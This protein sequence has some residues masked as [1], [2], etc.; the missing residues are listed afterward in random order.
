MGLPCHAG[1]PAS[2]G[3][4]EPCG[5][6]HQDPS[7]NFEPRLQV[8]KVLMLEA[9]VWTL[10]N[11]GNA[12]GIQSGYWPPGQKHSRCGLGFTVVPSLSCSGC[13]DAECQRGSCSGGMQPHVLS[14]TVYAGLGTCEDWGTLL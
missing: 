7:S 5:F 6:R 12:S 1:P 8:A 9:L 10:R 13:R 11:E 4:R 3:N 14:A 2:L